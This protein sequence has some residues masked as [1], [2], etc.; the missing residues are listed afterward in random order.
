[1]LWI[2]GPFLKLIM[3]R[4]KASDEEMDGLYSPPSKPEPK[5]PEAKPETVDQEEDMANTAVIDN[6]ILSPEGEPLKEGDEVTL[7]VVKNYGEECEVEYA[8]KTEPS[9]GME[10]ESEIDSLET[11][12]APKE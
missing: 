6:K 9:P 12:T 7:R 3:P 4:Y 5:T 8:P 10:H 1:V 2:T 11:P